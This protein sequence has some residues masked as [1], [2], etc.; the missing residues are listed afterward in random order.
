VFAMAYPAYL[1]DKA[2]KLSVENKL[3]I[4]EI[5]DRLAL[6]KTTI[7]YWVRDLPLARPRRANAGQRKGNRAMREKYRRLREEAY[8][9]GRGEFPALARIRRSVTSSA[10]TSARVTSTTGTAS[11]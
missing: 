9:R 5:A 11:G 2:R 3:S 8:V 1:R 6:P 10:C 4:V 7:W